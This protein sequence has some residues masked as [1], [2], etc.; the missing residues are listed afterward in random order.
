VSRAFRLRRCGDSRV[1]AGTFGDLLRDDR[2]MSL[3]LIWQRA[4]R[5]TALARLAHPSPARP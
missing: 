5:T 1:P 4:K 2:G 3:C